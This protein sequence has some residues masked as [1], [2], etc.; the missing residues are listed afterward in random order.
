MILAL[1]KMI[2]P[3]LC[4]ISAFSTTWCAQTAA[5]NL[6]L[7]LTAETD[8]ALIVHGNTESK[9]EKVSTQQTVAT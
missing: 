5:K 3:E 9:K 7:R 4:M 2:Q 1:Q 8:S 6:E